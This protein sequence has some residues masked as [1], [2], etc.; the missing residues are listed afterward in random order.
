MRNSNSLKPSSPPRGGERE[1]STRVEVT[2]ERTHRHSYTV[3]PA[4]VL[5]LDGTVR[6]SKSGG[7]I[8][9]PSDQEPMYE[10]VGRV[11]QAYR[12]EGYYIAGLTNQGG[13]AHGH[14]TE[15]DVHEG[16]RKTASMIAGFD[17]ILAVP[18]SNGDGATV[19][20]YNRRSLLRKPEMGGLAVI[21]HEAKA[22]SG[23]IINWEESVMVGDRDTDR[24]CAKKAGVAY[25]DAEHFF[26]GAGA[27]RHLNAPDKIGE[28]EDLEGPPF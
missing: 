15:D 27:E 25:H 13:V 19:E 18:F 7:F 17:Y 20:P 16:L 9:D 10:D 6:K 4:L 2:F 22:S 3:A 28:A 11:L 8:N 26:E 23:V 21:E 14:L 12:R 1:A 5:D 24:Q